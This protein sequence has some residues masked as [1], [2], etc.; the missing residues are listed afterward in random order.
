MK[1]LPCLVLGLSVL[2]LGSGCQHASVPSLEMQKKF[3]ASLK[4]VNPEEERALRC[5]QYYKLAGQYDLALKEL[6]RALAADPDNVRLLNAKGSCHD[7]L[8]EYGQAQEMYQ[9]ILSQDAV[10]PHALNNSAYSYYLAGNF[11]QAEKT[12]QKLLGK[13]PEN[14][15]ARNNLGL[16]YCRQGKDQQALRLW[17]KSDGE[18]GARE[19]L[20]QVLTYL[21]K[22]SDKS[23][24][25][26]P[27]AKTPDAP[28]AA[29]EPTRAPATQAKLPK[30]AQ[31]AK[32]SA[33]AA[34]ATLD[35][36]PLAPTAAASPVPAAPLKSPVQSRVKVEEVEMVIQPASYSVP[37]T[38]MSP[39]PA[40]LPPD[41]LTPAAPVGQSTPGR[42]HM[43]KSKDI[44]VPAEVSQAQQDE[45]AIRQY[46]RPRQWHR[47]RPRIVN[48]AP[49]SPKPQKSL[50]E[51]ISRGYSQRN[52]NAAA[53]PETTI[54]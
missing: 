20:Q 27:K 10:N 34:P 19:K 23:V 16:V 49:E 14:T 36:I 28:L 2:L 45:P 42:A 11:D 47:W 52:Q 6:N 48:Y 46:H 53:K 43:P 35:E 15:L 25:V 37:Q 54:Y 38:E 29:H 31:A 5:A 51:Y 50:K 32:P 12:F 39:V 13:Y 9:K 26:L 24:A 44:V 40:N 41:A 18:L 4:N 21:G 33:P 1:S 3:F 22:P 7:R 30:L 8:G 17:E